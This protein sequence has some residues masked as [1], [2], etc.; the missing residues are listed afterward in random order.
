MSPSASS[1]ERGRRS[2]VRRRLEWGGT[3]TGLFLVVMLASVLQGTP[4]FH[5]PDILEFTPVGQP[6]PTITPASEPGPVDRPDIPDGAPD[7][8][9]LPMLALIAIGIVLAV[10][11]IRTLIRLWRD[12]PAPPRDAVDVDAVTAG[13]A[14]EAE[15]MDEQ[16]VR[17]GI[18]H[19]AVAMAAQARPADAIVAAWLALEETAAHAGSARGR[20]ETPAEFTL[21]ILHRRPG[22]E[23]ATHTLLALY[24]G[25]RFG[26][27]AADEAARERAAESLRTIDEGWR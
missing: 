12:R 11:L 24:E 23:A 6:A 7:L 5:P 26:G 13:T 15:T 22:I 27:H 9:I 18:A 21:R 1:R 4:T 16:V 8:G 17:R 20:S 2:P 14:T 3:V 25:V 19:A 10:L